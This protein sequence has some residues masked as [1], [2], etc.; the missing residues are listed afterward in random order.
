VSTAV[1][2]VP[3]GATVTAEWHHGL[4]GA[5]P[6]DSSDPIDPS[7]KGPVISYLAKVNSATQTDVTGLKWFKIWEDGFRASDSSWGVDRLYANKGKGT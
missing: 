1:I 6:S 7:H 5:V 2:N 4:D 3:A